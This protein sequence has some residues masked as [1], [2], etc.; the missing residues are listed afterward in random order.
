LAFAKSWAIAA[1]TVLFP[2]AACSPLDVS[3]N[4]PAQSVNPTP[5]TKPGV[6]LTISPVQLL[7]ATHGVTP[8]AFGKPAHGTITYGSYG[9]MIYTPDA[10]FTGIDQLPVTVS[11]AVR[12][13]AED[14][15]PL[16][17]IGEVAIQANAHGSAIAAVPGSTDEI[18]GLTDRGPAVAGRSPNEVVLPM[19]DLHPQI[20]KFKLVDGVASLEQIIMLTG[21]DGKPLVGLIDPQASTGET[22]VDLNGNQLAR[23]DHGLD[24]EGL[25]AMA[26]GTF[27]VSDDYGPFIVHFDAKGKELE[28]LSPFDGTL[29]RELALRSPNQ[30]MEGLTITPDGTTLVG[31][32]QSALDTPG[33]AGSAKS[34]PVI[35]LVTVNL[36]DRTNVHEYLYP[37]ANPQD[38][39][40]GVSDITALSATTFLIDER[41]GAPEPGG[42]KK[43]YVADISGATDVGPRSTVPRTSYLADAGGLLVNGVPIETFVG[44][45]TDGVAA[46]KL[47]AVGITVAGKTLKLD[48]GELVR[49]LSANGDFFGHDK[50]EGVISRDG[51]KTLMVANDS[52]FGLAG[53]ASQTPPFTLKPKILPNGT[54]DSGEILTVDTTLLPAK[55]ETVMVPIKV[56]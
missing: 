43:I 41:D 5:S 48:L 18:Y 51:G 21:R 44:V 35:R 11:P 9:A 45:S 12:V 10:G 31:V 8:V 16:T 34:V 32:M 29:P 17:I 39:K 49:A 25:V 37:L 36:A 19:P 6:V 23:S 52:D 47:K 7:A 30:G 13:Y 56:G 2:V 4:D 26:D 42:N 55:M 33:L 1:G 50:I 15:P 46:D 38:T 24:S 14:Q 20:A 22:L 53:L 3:S 28:R 27:W 54:Q 40:V